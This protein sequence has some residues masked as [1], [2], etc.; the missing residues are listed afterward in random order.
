MNTLVTHYSKKERTYTGPELSPHFILSQ[1]KLEG[2]AL[3]AWQGGA[4]VKTE[5]LVDWEDRLVNDHI[6]AKKMLHFMGEFFGLGL[7]EG[8]WLQRTFASM[9]CDALNELSKTK[10]KC[11]WVRKGDDLYYESEKGPKLS[12]SIVTVSGVSA[13][14]HFAMNLDAEGAPVKAIGLYEVFPEFKKSS[15]AVEKFT[16]TLLSRFENEWKSVEKAMVKV[17]PLV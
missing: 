2:S 11:L 16:K 1:F 15:A 7:R 12:V 14:F 8:T 10:K 4:L 17:R 13:L 6:Q 3:V 9:V 5:H